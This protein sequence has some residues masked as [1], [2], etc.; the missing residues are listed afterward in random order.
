MMKKE[1]IQWSNVWLIEEAKA[2]GFIIINHWITLKTKRR[3]PV[4]RC[5]THARAATSLQWTL[6]KVFMFMTGE[7]VKNH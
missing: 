4:V 2:Q 6:K 1:K 7:S 5:H 3:P